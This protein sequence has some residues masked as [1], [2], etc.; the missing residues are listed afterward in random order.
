LTVGRQLV[1]G[2]QF[3]KEKILGQILD[4]FLWNDEIFPTKRTRCRISV[5]FVLAS[6]F[7]ALEAVAVETRQ[8]SGVVE[9]ISADWTFSDVIDL[10]F[11]G[12]HCCFSHRSKTCN[13]KNINC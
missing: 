12:Q 7:D 6:F 13:D 4:S 11:E 10:L 2:E 9:H 5:G 3:Q 1:D 8:H